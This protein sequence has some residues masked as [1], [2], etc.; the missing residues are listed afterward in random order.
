ML[1]VATAQRSLPF[2]AGAVLALGPTSSALASRLLGS[3]DEHL[4]RLQAVFG[5]QLLLVLGDTLDL[6]W[7]DGAIYLGREAGMPELWLPCAVGPSVPLPLLWRALCARFESA[8]LRGPCAIS[9]EPALVV[10][11][12]TAQPLTRAQLDAFRAEGRAP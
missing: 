8:R 5:A 9:L 6:P 11:L 10:P 1:A 12:D 2:T 4:E 7:S 3:T